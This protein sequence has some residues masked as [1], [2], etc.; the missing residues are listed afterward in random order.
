MANDNNNP[1]I[2]QQGS[3]YLS[4][5][6]QHNLAFY[7]ID[8]ARNMTRDSILSIRNSHAI[9]LFDANIRKEGS[10]VK[11]TL[12]NSMEILISCYKEDRRKLY[13]AKKF[14]EQS[15]E[16]YDRFG[17]SKSIDYLSQAKIWIDEEMKINN[18]HRDLRRLLIN[19]RE[20]LR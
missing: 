1:F 12:D 11:N 18:W 9:I 19:I 8:K 10:D 5:K 7:W 4:N 15:I 17:D 14:A 16:Y 6:Q 2:L 3:L 13:H 20:R